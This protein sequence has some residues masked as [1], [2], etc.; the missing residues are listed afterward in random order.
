MKSRTV[1]RSNGRT[2]WGVL[3]ACTAM[4]ILAA[5]G[6]PA[7]GAA[8]GDPKAGK[9]QYEK[10][11]AVCHGPT[12]KGDGQALRGVPVRPK[13]FADPTALRGVTDQALFNTI[14]K[15][16]AGTDKSPLMPPFGDQLKEGQIRDLVAYIRS[17]AP[18]AR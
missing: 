16:G 4:A 14:Q 11:C 18:P 8:R 9:E 2:L 13:S 12:G 3:A 7:R 17:L 5:G 15:G 10:L 6:A 1:E